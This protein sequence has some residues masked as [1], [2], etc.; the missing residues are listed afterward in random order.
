[1][2]IGENEPFTTVKE[3]E[4][5][6]A[7]CTASIAF[8]VMSFL[9]SA[10]IAETALWSIAI[11]NAGIDWIVEFQGRGRNLLLV[12]IIDVSSVTIFE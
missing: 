2:D 5:N 11:G 9:L 7:V 4:R 12:L 8:S 1:M 10:N 6:T 3:I